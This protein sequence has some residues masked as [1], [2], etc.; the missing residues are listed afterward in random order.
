MD[1]DD[2]N[3]RDHEVEIAS[4][5]APGLA[6]LPAVDPC[7][8]LTRDEAASPGHAA[9]RLLRAVT[10]MLVPIVQR[11]AQLE[12]ARSKQLQAIDAVVEDACKQ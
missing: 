2:D 12:D 1:I 3:L 6:S 10:E 8:G 7:G 9:N 5:M 4:I 11:V